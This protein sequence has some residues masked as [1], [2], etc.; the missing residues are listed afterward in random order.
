MNYFKNKIFRRKSISRNAWIA[1][2]I[3]IFGLIV[4]S[5]A[6]YYIHK[7]EESQSNQEFALICNEIKSK[8]ETRLHAH[9]QLLRSSAASFAISD[10]FTR[11]D[12][13]EFINSSR[14]E[15]NLPGIQGVGFSYIVPKSELQQ[16][17]QRIQNESKQDSTIGDYNITPAG[18][19]EIYTSIIYL[20]PVDFRNRRAFGYD[21]FSEPVRRKAMEESRDYDIAS[22]SGKVSLKQETDTDFQ[23]GTLMYV[24]V[25]FKYKP[26]ETVEERRAAILG[27]VYSPYRMD[28]LMKGILG[29]WDTINN[30]R[31]HLQVYDEDDLSAHSLLFNSQTKIDPE[32]DKQKYRTVI[33][34]IVFNKKKW[35]LCFRQSTNL[36]APFNNKVAIV[37][38]SGLLVSFLLFFLSLSLFNTQLKHQIA[39]QLSADL[40]E[41]ENQLKMNIATK[42][43]LFSIIAHDLKSPFHSILGL[44]DHLMDKM[45]GSEDALNKR[46]ITHINSSAKSTLVLLDNLLNW[47]KTQTGQTTITLEKQ[48]FSSI[49]QEIFEL[50]NSVAKDKNIV[51]NFLEKEEIIVH[52][53][54][55]MVKTILRNLISN[56]IKFT[57][58]NGEINVYASQNDRFIEITVS[59]NGV[60]IDEETQNKLF[61]L[62]TNKSTYGTEETQN[63]L[64]KLETNKSTYGTE[65][66]K[67]SGLGL[68]LCKEFVEKH[69]GE[70]WVESELGKGSAFKFTL[71]LNL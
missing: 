65:N 3:F 26:I 56:A 16:H 54:L 31:I 1:F 64:F 24:P 10:T 7:D 29:R 57:K 27:W 68:I 28:D 30:E 2:I 41:S 21:M 9:S 5:G 69:G 67:G 46:V 20:E 36:M 39:E 4:T 62:E 15:K 59:D 60:G 66:E 40:Q 63:K 13:K 70:I 53:D 38:S 11:K 50:S 22:L 14:I 23:Y 19:R 47:S 34:P 42:D 52:A 8:I 32:H 12:W 44:S 48:N 33:L 6:T 71:P 45:D 37:F 43:K 58:S 49:I 17:I 25:Y 18:E 51:L 35:T 55:N 61:K